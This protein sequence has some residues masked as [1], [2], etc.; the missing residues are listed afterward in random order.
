M[1]R[2]KKI[3]EDEE[4]KKKMNS[5]T[6]RVAPTVRPRGDPKEISKQREQE[7]MRRAREREKD[8]AEALE[9]AKEEREKKLKHRPHLFETEITKKVRDSVLSEVEKTLSET[10][11]SYLMDSLRSTK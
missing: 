6:V 10:G 8:S 11:T 2:Q 9:R 1:R 7:T 3:E 5:A 4:W